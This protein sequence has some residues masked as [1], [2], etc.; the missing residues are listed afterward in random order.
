MSNDTVH[1]LSEISKSFSMVRSD[2]SLMPRVVLD[3]LESVSNGSM[4]VADPNNP[5]ALNLEMAVT[6]AASNLDECRLLTRQSYP[7]LTNT[8]EELYRHMTDYD[9]KD[10]F[11]TPAMGQFAILMDKEEL[12]S[13]TV[14]DPSQPGTRRFTI[15][16][17][18]QINVQ[19]TPFTLLYPIDIRLVSHGGLLVNYDYSESTPLH[20]LK[21]NQ[22]KYNI[23]VLDGREFVSIFADFMQ[24]EITRYV[25]KL[26]A[27]SGFSREYPVTDKFYFCRAF[28]K[29][30]TGEWQE[31]RTTHSDTVYDPKVPTIVLSVRDDVLKVSVPQIY[32]NN[33]LIADAVRVDIYNT[34]GKVNKNISK[35]P[36]TSFTT[37]WKNRANDAN[38]DKFSSGILTLNRY[39]VYSP[40]DVI[41]GT[42]AMSFEELRR[43][44]ITRSISSEGLPVT[45]NQLNNR[46]NDLGYQLVTNIDN[47]TDRQFLATRLPPLP[48][49]SQTVNGISALI[50]T[51]QE[52]IGNLELSNSVIKNNRRHTI[53]PSQLYELRD[54]RLELVPNLTKDTLWGLQQV[55]ADEL[56]RSLNDHTYLYTPYYYVL[57]SDVNNFDCRVYHLDNPSIDSRFFSD[58]NLELDIN[59]SMTEYAFE[60]APS[61]DGYT[62]TVLLDVGGTL[63]ELG[64]DFIDIQL[65]YK[66]MDDNNR[67]TIPAKLVSPIDPD[68][69]RPVGDQYLY[70]FHIQTKYD[71]NDR[72]G[73]IP[74]PYKSP[75]NLTHEF[76]V[77][78]IVKD[79]N[80]KQIAESDIDNLIDHKLITDYSPSKSYRGVTHEKLN[81]VFG[82]RLNH[83]WQRTR[84]IMEY[85]VFERY[86]DDILDIYEEDVYEKDA[87]GQT[88]II[89]DRETN[90]LKFNLIH[91][92]GDIVY[93][94]YGAPVYKHRK[95]EVV[96][97]TL[98]DPVYKDNGRGIERHIDLFLLDAR[99][100]FANK[101]EDAQY[102]DRTR[103]VVADWCTVDMVRIEQELLEKS[104]IYYYP[105]RTTG[106]VEVIADNNLNVSIDAEQR[107]NVTYWLRQHSYQNN[108]LRETIERQ[109][110]ETINETLQ[111]TVISQDKII[112]NLRLKMSGNIVGLE[113]TGFTGDKYTTVTLKDGSMGLTIAKKVNVMSNN[114]LEVVNDVSVEFV[115]H[116]I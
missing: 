33:G 6:L 49:N 28:I 110:I 19:N 53:T 58:S 78:T 68:T 89:Y 66:G 26:N 56:A 98:G 23:V 46:V 34:Q 88:K 93:D 63:L 48:L 86:P 45:R 18:T 92:K 59:L 99:Y 3:T 38:I 107:F 54:N 102:R 100:L 37:R 47:I 101:A 77:I 51:L 29:S 70:Q 40:S 5:Y 108:S 2:P 39:L 79:Y 71:I 69:H 109:T 42:N 67:Y 91:S 95:N 85:D 75:V 60:V 106:S 20:V 10:V 27:S 76:D 16:R 65:S 81:L 22:L 64:P 31:I 55:N 94:Q 41:G 15:P 111:S 103:Q 97:D 61:K 44:V 9:Y 62:L 12:L 50:G 43:R 4:I 57:E 13:K 17:Y 14:E 80:P 73:L 84:S 21:S 1:V 8:W 90:S 36:H 35:L 87:N 32:A 116:G 11:A 30:E 24:T 96:M 114:K 115:V 25:P 72:D 104:E 82:K 52:T 74:T 105:I 83:L 7:A 112:D 113:V